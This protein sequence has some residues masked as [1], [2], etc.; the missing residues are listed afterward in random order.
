MSLGLR[1][2]DVKEKGI[3]LVPED[4]LPHEGT[5]VVIYDGVE[6]VAE[7]TIGTPE[8]KFRMNED[9][10]RWTRGLDEMV[11]KTVFSKF[12][13]AS[14]IVCKRR[15]TH[16]DFPKT[17]VVGLSAWLRCFDIGAEDEAGVEMGDVGWGHFTV[18]SDFED[19]NKE[20]PFPTTPSS[21]DILI[22]IESSS[23]CN[24]FPYQVI[25]DTGSASFYV[26]DV[27][28]RGYRPK[29]C[30]SSKC[31]AGLMCKVFCPHQT[32][33][34][35]SKGTADGCNKKNLY[36]ATASTSYVKMEGKWNVQFPPVDAEGFLGNDT[37][38]LGDPGSKQLIVPGTVFGQASKFSS[39]FASN[40]IDGVLGLTFPVVASSRITPPISRA[41]QLH[42]LDLPLFTVYLKAA[43]GK[44]DVDGGTI[45]LGA[46]DTTHCGPL[47]AY[48]PL[49]TPTHWQIQLTAVTSGKFHSIVKCR[50]RSSTANSF[51]GVPAQE[52]DAIASEHNA[53]WDKHLQHHVV[54]C[55]SRP[56]LVL[57][58]GQ[59]NYTIQSQNLVVQIPDGRCILAMKS[60][61]RLKY[62]KIWILGVPFHRQYCTIHDY[63]QER[64]G[65]AESVNF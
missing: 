8:Q 58:I 48:E 19:K 31:D 44:E 49:T 65:F 53:T 46:V 37:I 4:R 35:K 10:K 59:Q 3:S 7:V 12:Y 13:G 55:A 16:V 2:R 15:G 57:T 17:L 62:G 24:R 5:E 26:P 33:C 14:T 61:P 56:T 22:Q 30:D 43:K 51:I 42:L 60:S 34:R 27:S 45:T 18:L 54:E 20:N 25:M 21:Q 32:C 40:E 28:C 36:N 63:E 41:I 38:R 11:A 29:A 9:A 47:I 1:P 50:A 6:Y 39:L 23:D 64:I 52:L